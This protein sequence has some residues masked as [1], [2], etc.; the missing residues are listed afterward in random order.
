MPAFLLIFRCLA[1]LGLCLSLTSCGTTKHATA[2]EQLLLSDAVDGAVARLDFTPMAGQKVYFDTSFLKNQKGVG[3]VNA[4]YVVGSL[5][6]QMVAAGLLLQK[7]ENEAD[8]VIE[9]RLGALGAD[10]HDVIYG[11]PSTRS[12]NDAADAF[13]SISQLPSVP[14]IPELALAKRS[15]QQAATK[16]AV[17][18]YERESRERV[19]Q[20]GMVVSRSTAKDLWVLGAGPFQKGTIHQGRVK[21]AGSSLD[22]P[23]L[24]NDRHGSHG[25]IA[26][27]RESK[28]FNVPSEKI[29]TEIQQASGEE[30]EKE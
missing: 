26:S 20:S 30:S 6:Q 9:G 14:G 12:L 25:P 19:W 13:A 10:S 18:A 28:V 17:F 7:A 15:D 1:V 21:F 11:I 16:L 29:E 23:L 4:D 27:Y 22:V 5:R 8:F 24:A 3:F 2:T